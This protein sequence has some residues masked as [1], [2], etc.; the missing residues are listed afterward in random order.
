MAD[1]VNDIGFTQDLSQLDRLRQAAVNGDK[2]SEKHALESA[3]KQFE[4]IFTNMLFK[5]MRDANSEFKSDLFDSQTEDFYRKML[6][7]QRA[8]E[9][10]K[11]G[12]LGL[13]DMIV[14]QLSA[15]IQG[16][17]SA[18]VIGDDGLQKALA[19]IRQAKEAAANPSNMI[20][21]EASSTIRQSSDASFNG[22]QDFVNKLK[23]YADRAAKAL[24]VDPSLLLAQA[25]LE[26]GWG[27]NVIKN[28]LGSSNNL[29]NIKADKSWAGN[30]VA[31]QT[32]E[33]EGATPVL[34][35][36]SFR[37]YN[38]FQDSFND[39]VR[40]LNSNPRYA[41]A[42]HNS[43]DSND[44]IRGIHDAGYA[45]DPDYADK[46]LRVKNQIEQMNPS[47]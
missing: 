12:S 40:F 13:A 1:S 29:F 19:R 9:L 15:G 35:Q 18:S 31:T 43:K 10:S 36:A 16:T 25:A 21:A 7:E 27:D 38:N 11:S 8:S 20:P 37:A 33:Y 39:Y 28:S 2:S 34:E 5:S 45:T 30:K 3:A 4:S 46:V 26:T 17:D 42:L 22:P 24:G 14:K 47:L 6:D 32:L 41:N 44:F 23:P